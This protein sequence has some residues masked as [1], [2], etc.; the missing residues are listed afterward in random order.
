MEWGAGSWGAFSRGLPIAAIVLVCSLDRKSLDG[1]HLD[2]CLCW[3]CPHLFHFMEGEVDIPLLGWLALLLDACPLCSRWWV[4]RLSVDAC[5]PD[6]VWR[7]GPP[8]SL[9]AAGALDS[10][11]GA[12]GLDVQG[13]ALSCTA[14]ASCG[15]P[16]CL[17]P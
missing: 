13:T 1:L 3:S 11:S 14:T 15:G 6:K 9:A 10:A 12:L 8:P 4:D 5:V 16:D 7:C 17:A 2:Y